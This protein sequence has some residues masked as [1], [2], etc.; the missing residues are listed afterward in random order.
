MFINR[1]AN[2]PKNLPKLWVTL[3]S[4]L[5]GVRRTDII[6]KQELVGTP[7]KIKDRSTIKK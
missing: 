3:D 4:L 7:T 5:R 2:S 6:R 1:S